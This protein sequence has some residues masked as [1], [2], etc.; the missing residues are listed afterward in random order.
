MALQLINDFQDYID[1]FNPDVAPMTTFLWPLGGG[2]AY[3][4]IVLILNSKIKTPY[5]MRTFSIYHNLFL[6][7]L[8][9][10]MLLGVELSAYRVAKTKG[11][12]YTFCDVPDHPLGTMARGPMAFWMWIF[13][14]SKYYEMVDTIIL[15]LKKGH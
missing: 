14:A 8:S 5:S 15:V 6:C 2:T 13:Y 3:V 12:F 10:L 1:N 7:L 9:L 4:V 11:L